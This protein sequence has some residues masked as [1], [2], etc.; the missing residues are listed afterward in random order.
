M[1]NTQPIDFRELYDAFVYVSNERRDVGNT[2]PIDYQLYA[3]YTNIL[4]AF[5]VILKVPLQ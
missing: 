3:E 2:F 1:Q 4:N 5:Y